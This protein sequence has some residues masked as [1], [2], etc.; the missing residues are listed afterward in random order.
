MLSP[1]IWWKPLFRHRRRPCAPQ[2]ELALTSLTAESRSY[3]IRG[4]TRTEKH[5]TSMKHNRQHVMPTITEPERKDS[6]IR[7]TDASGKQAQWQ[8]PGQVGRTVFDAR[9]NS[10]SSSGLN[11]IGFR[12]V[13]E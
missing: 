3:K 7:G 5:F 8:R 12:I 4:N 11:S 6:V 13:S 10:G 1:I 9:F 2:F